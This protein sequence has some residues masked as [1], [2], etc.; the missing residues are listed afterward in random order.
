MKKIV[1]IILVLAVSLSLCGCSTSEQKAEEIF[2]N[3]DEAYNLTNTFSHDIYEAWY[4][5]INEVSKITGKTSSY[6]SY[7]ESYDYEKGYSYFCDQLEIEEQYISSALNNLTDK[8]GA[9]GYEELLK[10]SNSTFSSCVEIVTEAYKASGQTDD[11]QNNIDGAKELLIK[12]SKNNP[13]YI[14]Y[15]DLKGYLAETVAFYDF[16]CD[17]EGSFDQLVETSNAYRNNSRKYYNSLALFFE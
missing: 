8:A 1:S 6:Y 11:I 9:E 10:N 7:S 16:C 2:K 13:K 14:H 4:M 5:G 12:I 15:S 17:P 3:T